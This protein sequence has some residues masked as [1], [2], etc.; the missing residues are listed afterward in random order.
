MLKKKKYNDSSLQ[1]PVIPRVEKTRKR[2]F[3]LGNCDKI[4]D[5]LFCVPKTL[6]IEKTEAQMNEQEKE[7]NLKRLFYKACKNWRVAVVAAFIGAAVIGGT[8]CTVEFVKVHDPEVVAERQT[9]Y[10][11]EL[12]SSEEGD[13]AWMTIDEMRAGNMVDGMDLYFRVYLDGDVNEI[14]YESNSDGWTTMLK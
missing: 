5:G 8:K 9:E 2:L 4:N 10:E 12:H 7:I 3:F 1:Y 11:G 6:E 14:W 13:I